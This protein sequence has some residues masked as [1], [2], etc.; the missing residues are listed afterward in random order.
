MLEKKVLK[1][2]E[3]DVDPPVAKLLAGKVIASHKNPV[4]VGE[5]F[6]EVYRL[7]ISEVPDMQ[8]TEESREDLRE[9]DGYE[10]IK[11]KGLVDETEW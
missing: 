3:V 8:E 10:D 5:A 1:L 2:M 4:S 6:K 7:Y 11:R 9:S